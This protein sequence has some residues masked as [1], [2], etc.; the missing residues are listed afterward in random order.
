MNKLAQRRIDQIISVSG[1]LNTSLS[2][3]EK[4]FGLNSTESGVIISTYDIAS[5]LAV[6]P[7][8]YFGQA[9]RKPRYLGAGALLIAAGCF[10]FFLPEAFRNPYTWLSDD[11][12]QY[13]TNSPKVLKVLHSENIKNC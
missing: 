4:V 3:I 6:I 1:F 13:C 10:V 5:L 7:V 8:T 2:T 12:L 11:D 9:G